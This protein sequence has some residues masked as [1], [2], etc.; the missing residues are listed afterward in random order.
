V[1]VIQIECVNAGADNI[2]V[3]KAVKQVFCE[4]NALSV[5]ALQAKGLI[6]KPLKQVKTAQLAVPEVSAIDLMNPVDD[7][8]ATE[9]MGLNVALLIQDFRS[10]FTPPV[11]GVGLTVAVLDTG[12]R[13][14]HEAIGADKVVYEEDFSGSGS[15]DDLYG[16]GT[17]VA[18]LI[19]GGEDGD[20]NSGIAPGAVLMNIK[21][22]GD[23]G[24]G[25]DEMVINAIS[26]VCDLV[27]DAINA[28][29]PKT[30]PDYPNL[31]NLSVGGEDDGEEDDPVKLACKT[32]REDYGLQIV[33]AA[34]N[35]GPAAGS[36]LLPATAIDVIAVG[37]IRSDVF[38]IWLNSARGPAP[39][40]LV[41]PDFVAWCT[42]IYAAGHTAD[43]SY[44][45]KTGTSFAAP[46][47]S[48]LIGLLWEAGRRVNG[49]LWYVDWYDVRNI[50]W[51]VAGKAK[52]APLAKDNTWGYGLPAI[53]KMMEGA[54]YKPSTD[55]TQ[56]METM[57]P[58]MMM[59]F[60]I[61]IPIKM[62]KG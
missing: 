55:M 29:Y 12:I 24:E 6:V 3:A 31:I 32:A 14:T 57:I 36:I 60:M 23:D 30:H 18:Y 4:L 43:D 22:L 54:G 21:C 42:D 11:T 41:K 28:S 39:D 58:M 10:A 47:L 19:A 9:G 16:H 38:D 59:M 50:G 51:L 35:S 26:K 5:A 62:L 61:I 7:V 52:D 56:I 1:G 34:G 37:G 46:I 40:G 17:A 33:A 13:K 44:V 2:S 8:V 15:V 20:Q 27:Q 25:T 45:L 53:S 49:D 48:G